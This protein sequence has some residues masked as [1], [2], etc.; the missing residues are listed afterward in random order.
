[1]RSVRRAVILAMV[2]VGTAALSLPAAAQTLTDNGPFITFPPGACLPGGAMASEVHPLN[3]NVG[4]NQNAGEGYRVADDFVV[5]GP[6]SW[7]VHGVSIFC[8]QRGSGPA[9]TITGATLRI[10]DGPPGEIG[11]AVVFGDDSTNRLVWAGFT[12][13]YRYGSGACSVLRP[14]MECRIGVGA[15]LGPGVYWLDWS[16]SGLLPPPAGPWAVPVTIAGARGKSGGNARQYQPGTGQWVE[17]FEGSPGTTPPLFP[18]DLAFIVHGPA[19]CYAN[20]DGSTV[21]PVL[22]VADFVC[23]QS[24]FAAADT[25]ANCDGSTVPPV[26]NVADFLCFQTQFAAGCGP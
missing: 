2:A 19:E 10:W 15:T 14:V 18:Q 3:T 17:L 12:N 5:P 13:V 9:P 23:F 1:M 8:Y 6:G 26:L 11:S 22:N 16:A 20:C 7:T 21:P 4:Y 24:R 25:R